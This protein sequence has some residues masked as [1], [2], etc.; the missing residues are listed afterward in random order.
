L[1][2]AHSRRAFTLI[3]VLIAL[4][5]ILFL[6]GS[7]LSYLYSLL[8]RRDTLTKAA[9]QQSAAASIFEQL[10]HDLATTFASDASGTAGVK[11]DETSLTVRCR[12]TNLLSRGADL[13]DLQGCELRFSGGTLT[14]RRL[15]QSP[16]SFETVADGVERL[17]L[18]YFDGTEWLESF[19]SARTGE[20]PVA[21]EASL[22]FGE[23]APAG[24]E[25]AP[26]PDEAPRAPDRTRT[27]VVPDGPV[28]AWKAGAS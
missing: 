17:Q 21:I 27:M 18:R 5:L 3:E 4:S 7:L 26:A 19:D 20:L 2:Q 1:S 9:A 11:G 12:G 25:G 6:S 14:A 8:E 28:A 13:T 16:G 23:A 24:D 15:S 10:E 22:W